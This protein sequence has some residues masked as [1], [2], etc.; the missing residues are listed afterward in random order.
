[1]RIIT[2][3]ASTLWFSERISPDSPHTWTAPKLALFS[4]F[5]SPV[6][7]S[8]A[9]GRVLSLNQ[10]SA[11]GICRYV[12]EFQRFIILAQ[13]YNDKEYT[14]LRGL[15]RF[16]LRSVRMHKPNTLQETIRLA[17]EFEAAFKGSDSQRWFKR[18]N[19]SGSN[20][21]AGNHPKP[22]LATEME[23]DPWGALDPLDS[24]EVIVRHSPKLW[25]KVTT[26]LLLKSRHSSAK[27]QDLFADRR[28][29]RL[30]PAGQKARQ[31]LYDT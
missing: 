29:I 10:K 21:P 28:V 16:T 23:V 30:R 15:R 18:S 4:Y 7:V 19:E 1:V 17:L 25:P 27:T 6:K 20:H 14:F 24:V 26:K 5:V 2:E 9:N 22:T 8:D 12:T 11:E 3:D 31:Q 13:I